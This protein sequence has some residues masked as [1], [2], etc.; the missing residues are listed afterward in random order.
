MERSTIVANF[1][2]LTINSIGEVNKIGNNTGAITSYSKFNGFNSNAFLNLNTVTSNADDFFLIE[3]LSRDKLFILDKK[4]KTTRTKSLVYPSE[5]N[6]S[7]PALLLLEWNQSKKLL[8]RILKSNKNDSKSICY[9]LS[10]S[11]VTFDV[12]Y[13]GISFN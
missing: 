5:L 11:P 4:T 12:L 1:S 6:V 10:I 2:Y 3:R 8:E 9:L 7:D 13:T